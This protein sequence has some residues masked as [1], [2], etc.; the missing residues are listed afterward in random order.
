MLIKK[1]K[2]QIGMGQIIPCGKGNTANSQ[3]RR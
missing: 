3:E 2:D 1:E